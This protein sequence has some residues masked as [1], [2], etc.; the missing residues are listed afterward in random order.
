MQFSV[1]NLN[2][3]LTN[4]I[5]ELPVAQSLPAVMFYAFLECV[6]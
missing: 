1:P 4:R 5:S 2:L 6:L 3:K